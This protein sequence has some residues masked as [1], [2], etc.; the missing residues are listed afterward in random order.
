MK[1]NSEIYISVPM[2]IPSRIEFNAHRIFSLK[3]LIDWFKENSIIEKF[4]FIDDKLILHE[5][6]SLNEQ[7]INNSCG[8]KHGCAI[9]TL[10]KK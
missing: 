8:C 9:F 7:L 3:Y 2:G 1:K 10:R 5:D 4:T 6:V